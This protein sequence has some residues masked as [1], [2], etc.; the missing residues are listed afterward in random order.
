MNNNVVIS[1]I[2][3]ISE[4]RGV[5]R[6]V[7]AL[8]I[9]IEQLQINNKKIF[10]NPFF[11]LSGS[12]INKS[13]DKATDYSIAV[14][15]DIISIK[16]RKRFPLGP[17]G[18][19]KNILNFRN[20]KKYNLI[21]TDSQASAINIANYLKFSRENVKVAYPFSTLTSQIQKT[22]RPKN[23]P[24][25]ILKNGFALYVGDVNWHKNIATLAK[26]TV[27]ANIP[28]LCVGKAFEMLRSNFPKHKE[29]EELGHFKNI[30][31]ANR[32]HI[33]ILGYV[34]ES[35]LGWL[36]ENALV[37]MLISRDEGFGYSYV[38]A[39][40][41]GTPSILSDIA[42]F[43]E[44]SDSKGALF[45]N[46]DSVES[47]KNA[48]IEFKNSPEMRNSSGKDAKI[49]SLLFSEENFAR[50]WRKIIQGANLIS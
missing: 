14:I 47:I 45:V 9:V 46:Q 41:F 24:P 32:N 12:A 11:N 39:G 34:E 36:Y 43:R 4:K 20:L 2:D 48:I 30:W 29:L 27:E 42:I 8:K 38:E 23:L 50:S 25:E 33:H 28:L 16:N 31:E 44:I 49:R 6:Y 5:G 1:G 21:V 17:L 35:E 18:K 10:I 26:A 15:H 13:P 37:N 22:K 19:L 40:I 7:Q 3:K